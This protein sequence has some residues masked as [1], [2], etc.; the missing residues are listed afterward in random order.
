MIYE[1][2]DRCKSVVS[3]LKVGYTLFLVGERE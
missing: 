1:S 2:T 3:S